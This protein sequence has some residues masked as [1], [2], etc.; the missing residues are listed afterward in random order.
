MGGCTSTS[1]KIPSE[2]KFRRAIKLY[3]VTEVSSLTNLFNR[4]KCFEN[5]DSPLT[6]AAQEGHEAVVEALIE[7]GADV[8]MLDKN[9]R[10]ALHF[11]TQS[12]DL[13][14]VSIL[15]DHHGDPGKYDDC[16]N[17][18]PLHLACERGYV[19]IAE[20]LLRHGADSNESARALPPLVYA[21]A[22]KR[23]DCVELLLK[24]A[25]DPNCEDARGNSV[26]HTAVANG[27]ATSMRL[28]LS[29]GASVTEAASRDNDTLVCVSAMLGD[30]ECLQTL[31][32]AGGC[33]VNEHRAD[34]PPAVVASVIQGNVECVEA[35]LTAGA[36]VNT[37]DKRGQTA[38][39]MACMSMVDTDRAPFYC[40]YFSN[41][42]R[43]YAKYDPEE[44]SAENSCKC[45]MSLVQFGANITPVWQGFSRVFPDPS[46]ITFEQ[47]VLCEVLIQAYG[48]QQLSTQSCRQF[49]SKL[50]TIKEYSLVKLLYSAGV[51]PCLEDL[52][53][54]AV[55][56][57]QEEQDRQMFLWV[58]K[59]L[60]S[61]RQLK[62]LCRQKIRRQLSWNV[63]HLIERVPMS[64]ECKD[65][66]CIM[67]TEHYSIAE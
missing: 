1:L 31:I 42:Y 26:L 7:H 58:K 9:G 49:I 62:D 41:V 35:L 22:H 55:G 34:E 40:R 63:L 5:G 65:Y 37:H 57:G 19:R 15:L 33:D 67:D 28:L 13:E 54:L 50:C 52:S 64:T 39:Q 20:A 4:N 11:A 46:G 36:D 51:D 21:V 3:E 32:Q 10:G 66:V 2:K 61:P 16:Y 56:V 23:T 38:L 14:T 18:T 44:I 8:N 17:V 30:F 45:A 24:Y 12:N 53:I 60:Q 43:Q 29:H 48:F 27:D 59:L 47:M 6:L 25:A